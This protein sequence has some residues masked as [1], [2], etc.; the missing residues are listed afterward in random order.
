MNNKLVVIVL[1][2]L[3]S[4]SVLSAPRY[5]KRGFECQPGD[6]DLACP[7][8]QTHEKADAHHKIPLRVKP[9]RNSQV[10]TG[11]E[12]DRL[13]DE[14][15]DDDV[16]A[17]IAYKTAQTKRNY[18][19]AKRFYFEIPTQIFYNY[20]TTEE[21]LEAIRAIP[22][23]TQ[24]NAK[25]EVVPF[26]ADDLEK[27]FAHKKYLIDEIQLPITKD[28][29]IGIKYQSHSFKYGRHNSIGIIVWN[30]TIDGQSI[31]FRVWMRKDGS[32]QLM[33]DFEHEGELYKLRLVENTDY[34]QL[35]I[36]N[37]KDYKAFR[38][39]PANSAEA[40]IYRRRAGTSDAPD[41]TQEQHN[42]YKAAKEARR[43]A[44]ENNPLANLSGKLRMLKPRGGIHEP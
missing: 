38:N 3:V 12:F 22:P 42:R 30:G 19:G 16:G 23:K 4:A 34:H 17:F 27:A 21:D 6:D 29:T 36:I 33:T 10:L 20:T 7:A 1:A 28:T 13:V 5:Q 39:D 44:R 31:R 9:Y 35:V 43:K 26:T 18:P 2:L 25:G 37:A 14:V 15:K 40:R 8:F 32:T 41:F 24:I 11:S